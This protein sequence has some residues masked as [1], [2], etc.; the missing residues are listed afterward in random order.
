M[1]FF[2]F[3][4]FGKRIYLEAS[5]VSR[6]DLDFRDSF[7]YSSSEQITLFH[8]RARKL[9][10]VNLDISKA[11]IETILGGVHNYNRIGTTI[12]ERLVEN[13]AKRIEVL[14][15]ENYTELNISNIYDFKSALRLIPHREAKEKLEKEL[16]AQKKKTCIFENWC[17]ELDYPYYRK[18]NVPHFIHNKISYSVY[19]KNIFNK[20]NLGKYLSWDDRQMHI[21][22]V[23][24]KKMK[25]KNKSILNNEKMKQI[26]DNIESA[27]IAVYRDESYVR[28]RL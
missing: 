8:K 6:R 23:L 17:F 27:Y 5:Y 20:E 24:K 28:I 10:W 18:L 2:D 3:R 22:A 19:N 11:T 15:P 26:T 1:K 4:V 14:L 12:V 9:I 13:K 21:C 7:P 16:W 25:I